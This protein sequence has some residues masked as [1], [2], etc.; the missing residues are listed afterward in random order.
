MARFPIDQEFYRAY[1]TKFNNDRT[2]E[3]NFFDFGDTGPV[4][5]DDIK[6]IR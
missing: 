4:P 2:A 1:I 3:V 6:V 5:L